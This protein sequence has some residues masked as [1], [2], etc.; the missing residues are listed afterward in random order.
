MSF[1][2]FDLSVASF[3]ITALAVVYQAAFDDL[4]GN[5]NISEVNIS[6]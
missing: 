2:V 5:K 6:V 4:A 1:H 3:A